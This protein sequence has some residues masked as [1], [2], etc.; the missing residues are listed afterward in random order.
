MLVSGRVYGAIFVEMMKPK[1]SPGILSKPPKPKMLKPKM[2]VWNKKKSKPSFRSVIR[3]GEHVSRTRILAGPYWKFQEIAM[4]LNHCFIRLVTKKLFK[5]QKIKILN[6]FWRFAVVFLKDPIKH[7][8][9]SA[10]KEG[11][12]LLPKRTYLSA[13]TGSPTKVWRLIS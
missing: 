6:C 11:C 1:S 9:T 7:Q 2:K 3:K 10:S 12:S 13:Q 8:K 5:E 4:S